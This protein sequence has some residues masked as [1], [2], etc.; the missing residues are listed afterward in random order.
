MTMTNKCSFGLLPALALA[1]GI[2]LTGVCGPNDQTSYSPAYSGYANA[3]GYSAPAQTAYAPAYTSY[4]PSNGYAP[5]YSGYS[6]LPPAQTPGCPYTSTGMW[7]WTGYSWSW[8]AP[9]AVA[10]IGETGLVGYY[11]LGAVAP[12]ETIAVAPPA[13]GYAAGYPAYSGY[14]GTTPSLT[15]SP[16][17]DT[18]VGVA[19]LSLF[20]NG[21]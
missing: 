14:Y 13:Y 3:S 11:G 19:A 12:P 7:M 9:A 6:A 15:G 21:Q 8:C 5:A 17:L 1:A 18:L 20:N 2:A 16:L 4:A 10:P